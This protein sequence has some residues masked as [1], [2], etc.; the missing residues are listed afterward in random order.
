MTVTVQEDF[1]DVTGKQLK[2][3]KQGTV[4]QRLD[5]GVNLIFEDPHE[6]CGVRN[7]DFAKLTFAVALVAKPT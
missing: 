1:K 2:E 6:I 3:G 7:D 5:D 4:K